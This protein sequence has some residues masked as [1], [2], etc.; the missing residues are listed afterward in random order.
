MTAPGLSLTAEAAGFSSGSAA[1]TARVR[2]PA[3]AHREVPLAVGLAML[4]GTVACC[5]LARRSPSERP[6]PDAAGDPSAAAPVSK[7]TIAATAIGSIE[8][9]DA[10]LVGAAWPTEPTPAPPGDRGVLGDL[11]SGIAACYWQITVRI[12]AAG[13]GSDNATELFEVVL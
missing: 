11:A 1:S 6:R 5:L 9:P 7:A 12:A 2:A 13:W 8:A 10:A 3:A 4:G